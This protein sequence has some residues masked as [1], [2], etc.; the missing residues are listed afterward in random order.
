MKT[1]VFEW[2]FIREFESGMYKNNFSRA[3]LRALYNY[4]IDLEDDMGEEMSLDVV[5]IACDYTEYEDFKEVQR[6]Y[7]VETL[8][9]LE[10]HT[11]VIP[12]D[13]EPSSGRIIIQAY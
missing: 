12:V 4:L 3:G 9:E 1:E 5:A 11:T 8:E 13:D 7:N 6:D 10:Q 2:D